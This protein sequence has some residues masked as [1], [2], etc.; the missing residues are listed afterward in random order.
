MMYLIEFLSQLNNSGDRLPGKF[1]KF[2]V[3]H[4]SG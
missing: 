2:I 1:L 4:L 3:F